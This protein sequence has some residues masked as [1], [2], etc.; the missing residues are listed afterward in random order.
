MLLSRGARSAPENFDSH[1]KT[2]SKGNDNKHSQLYLEECLGG[3]EVCV[4]R[5][6]LCQGRCKRV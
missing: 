4:M 5:L 1:I 3:L 2:K 6:D